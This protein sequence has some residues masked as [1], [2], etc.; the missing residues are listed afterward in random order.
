MNLQTLTSRKSISLAACIGL[1]AF[2]TACSG[3]SN[4]SNPGGTTPKS[5]PASIALSST[6]TSVTVSG[7]ISVTATVTNDGSNGGVN[8]SCAPVGNCGSF[9]A[10][11]TAS[12]T[13]TTYSA[14]NSVPSSPVV[15]TATLVDDSTVTASTPAI[16]VQVSTTLAVALSTA[17]PASIAPKGT[18]TV[19]ASV[20]N[21]PENKGVSWSCSPSPSCGSFNPTN[22]ASA[23]NTVFTAGSTTGNVTII[24]TSASDASKNASGVI[25]VTS[26]AEASIAPGNYVF[27]LG[28]N[29]ANDTPYFVAG[30]FTVVSNGSG[31]VTI[32]TGEQDFSD[33][34]NYVHDTISSGTIAASSS[35]GDANWTITLQTGDPCIGPGATPSCTGGT[36]QETLDATL[37]TSTNGL[38]IED[39]AWATSSGTLD[40]QTSTS[41]PCASGG[42]TTP[43]AYAFVLNGTDG[44]SA[45]DPMTVGGVI[46]IDNSGG[47]GNISG[48]GSV[49]DVND[50]G[51]LYSDVLF[52]A[53]NFTGP[54]S[55]GMVTFNL[56]SNSAPL[57]NPI[58]VPGLTLVGY[59]VDPG[60][61]RVVEN[62][63]VDW[64]E[65]TTGGSALLQT[66]AGTFTNATV[67][68]STYVFGNGGFDPNGPLQS[69]SALTFNSDGSLTGN[70]SF[71]DF[72]AQSPQGGSTLAAEVQAT[73]CTSGTALTACYIIDAPGS[74]NDGGTGR[75]TLTNLTDNTTTP[76]FVYNLELYLTGD[77]HALVISM[78]N[79]DTQS[80]LAYQQSGTFSAASFAGSYV[81]NVDQ[82]DTVGDFEYDGV[83]TTAADGVGNFSGYLD[84]TGILSSPLS[85]DPDN[86]VAGTFSAN[87]NAIF[88]GSIYGI[89]TAPISGATANEDLF[90]FY[91]VDG[92]KAVAIQNGADLSTL[93]QLTLGVFELQQ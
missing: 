25:T 13:A 26:A 1:M 54:D 68:G 74:G 5:E 29:D 70:L 57:D 31:G 87:S 11:K 41:A 66:G 50:M 93:D 37:L 32:S 17:P 61:I 35:N 12:G 40:L 60:H 22:T 64:L 23:A 6:P 42:P 83:G 34:N 2:L 46:N 10:G 38:L 56:N 91:M 77:G 18:A 53:S 28:G 67:S 86:L 82:Q 79:G 49:F 62:W 48:N 16:T 80:G 3:S 78:D 85:P 72:I 20:T 51:T 43:C 73:P 92:T 55:M 89:S 9:S 88:T 30:V 47:A 75:V 63:N 52:T 14:P 24:A 58:P 7:T 65:G 69:A 15:I 90:T 33:Y 44:A 76:T 27:Y 45:Q 84:L 81:L 21:D 59:I 4:N 71:N 8:W 19:A 36:G 39:D